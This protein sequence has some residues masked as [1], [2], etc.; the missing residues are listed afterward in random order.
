MNLYFKT[1]IQNNFEL[2]VKHFNQDL[3]IALKPPLLPLDILRFDGVNQGDQFHLKLGP[4]NWIG[5]VI[6]SFQNEQEF[7][8]IDVGIKLPFPLKE[9]RHKHS[10]LKQDK[11]NCIIV[12]DISY[13]TNNKI[14]DYIIFPGM[15]LMFR[16]RGPLYKKY[17]QQLKIN[18][19]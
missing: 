8:F 4:Q 12:D 14:V 5:K 19:S 17:Y 13:S 6:S 16:L 3:F 7:E 15:W 11:N 18:K 9:W 1:K 2:T 10:V